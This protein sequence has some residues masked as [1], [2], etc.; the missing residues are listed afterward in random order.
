M[1]AELGTSE[2]FTRTPAAF[3]I[4]YDRPTDA[5]IQP[6]FIELRACES[7]YFCEHHVARVIRG[8]HR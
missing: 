2:K 7:T 6:V 4:N 5:Q 3:E 8:L 1:T